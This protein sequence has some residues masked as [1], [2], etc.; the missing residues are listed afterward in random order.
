MPDMLGLSSNRAGTRFAPYLLVALPLL[1][2]LVFSYYP[3]VNG[4]VHVFYQWDGDAIEEFTGLSNIIKAIHDPE[5]WQ[6]FGVVAIFIVSNVVKIIIPII[7][8]V[9]LHRI[10]SQRMQYVYRLGFIIPMIV[11]VMVS[12]LMWKYFYE[13]NAG[14][15]NNSLRAT[16]VIGPS[17]IIPW[18]SDRALV[19]PALVFRGFPY[20]GAFGVL[21]YLTGL[22]N[23][24]SELYEAAK[25]DGAGSVGIFL[26]IELPLIMTQ[27]R[28]TMVLMLITTIQGWEDVYL[29]LGE[30][31]GPGGI[32]TVPGLLIFRDAFSNGFYGYGC[33]IGFLVF[34][35]TLVL[36]YVNHRY[37]RVEK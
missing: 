22:Q 32:A 18:L 34:L 21:I 14:I 6:A 30:S 5:L 4:F 33:A 13:P 36:T 24:S 2:V 19:I 29:F 25:L 26:H 1:S 20:V 17:K 7:T 31:G 9:V 37:V 23:I 10:A 8:A 28:V 27:V 15:L 12:I 3:I 16:G 35:I 11:P